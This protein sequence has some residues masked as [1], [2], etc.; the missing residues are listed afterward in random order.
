MMQQQKHEVQAEI[1]SMMSALKR[2]LRTMKASTW[3]LHRCKCS[4]CTLT[5]QMSFRYNKLN[6]F[7]KQKCLNGKS[8]SD[9]HNGTDELS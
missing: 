8:F 3:S 6:D 4:M 1:H 5:Q 9:S 2:E 7:V